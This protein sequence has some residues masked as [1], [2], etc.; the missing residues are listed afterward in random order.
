VN[1]SDPAQR[2]FKVV[3]R[4]ADGLAYAAALAEKYRLTYE[5]VKSRISAG[6]RER[7]TS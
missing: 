2:T 3:R 6:G 5:S 4:A 7:M 1:P